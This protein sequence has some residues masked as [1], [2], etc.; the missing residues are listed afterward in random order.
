MSII[1]TSA[2]RVMKITLRKFQE[3][4]FDS[5]YQLV[6]DLRVMKMVTERA[7][8]LNEAKE[9]FAKLLQNDQI[10]ER[11]GHFMMINSNTNEFIGLGKLSIEDRKTERAEIGYLLLPKFWGKG[12]GHKVARILVEMAVSTKLKHLYAI[13]DPKNV[14]SRKIL[15]KQ[16]FVFHEY[17]SFDGLPGE[18][19]VKEL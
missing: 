18:I 12:I 16:G 9:D 6:G 11:F 14:A 1:F 7:F 17:K 13:I 4:D 2:M 8:D 15:E 19:L 3:T 5:Y 10:D